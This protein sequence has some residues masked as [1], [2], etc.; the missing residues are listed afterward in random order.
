M[1]FGITPTPY[2]WGDIQRFMEW[3]VKVEE[4]EFDAILMPDHYQFP[5]PPFYS[6]NLVDAWTTL[7][8]IS[9]KTSKIRLGSIVSPIPRYIPSQLAK[10]IA[11]VDLLSNGRV[12]AG[13]GVGYCSEE[14]VNYS[15][16]SFFDEPR[17]LFEKFKEGLDI[18]LK[19]W[20]NDKVT[21][22]GKYYALTDAVLLP[23]PFQKPHPPLWVGGM[24]KLM[25]KMAAKFFDCWIPPA[26]PLRV[27]TLRTMQSIEKYESCMRTIQEH[28]KHYGRKISDFTFGVLLRFALE[29]ND[30]V[31]EATHTIERYKNSGCQYAVI[32]FSP[33]QLK[34]YTEL[35][36]TFAQEV[37][38]SF[39]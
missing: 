12:I 15:P 18:I 10:L 37:M 26:I 38:P 5:V 11:N 16:A 17:V 3:C 23:K 34:K 31:R 14:F 7:S 13:F 32:E 2:V 27:S 30:L 35:T 25:L 20:K 24:G 19:L 6:N 36:K 9:A 1:K 39:I 29:A 33:T 28:L 4:M 21:F 22:K 8:Y